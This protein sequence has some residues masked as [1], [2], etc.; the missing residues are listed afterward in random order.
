M[1]ELQLKQTN[2]K[3]PSI[4]VG[5][6]RI[7]S[8]EIPALVQHIEFCVEQ[9]LTYFDHAD[10]YGGGNCETLFGKAFKETD[11]EREDIFVQ[12]KCGI[13]PG[14]MYDLSKKH[15]LESVDGILKRLDMEYLDALVLH[16]P[17]ALVEPRGRHLLHVQPRLSG[18]ADVPRRVDADRR[19]DASPDFLQLQRRDHPAGRLR[20]CGRLRPDRRR[21]PGKPGLC[22]QGLWRGGQCQNQCQHRSGPVQDQRGP[23]LHRRRHAPGSIPGSLGH[24]R[25]PGGRLRGG[26]GS[27]GIY[28]SAGAVNKHREKEKRQK[29]LFLFTF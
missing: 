29:L 9:G 14:V 12:S 1:R 21:L 10:I 7:D 28:E 4:A 17:D 6:M 24:P 18:V 3:I 19:A 2:T 8:M 20:L 16:R 13:V 23:G 27:D 15:I 25:G 26:S 22:N 5:C 11:V